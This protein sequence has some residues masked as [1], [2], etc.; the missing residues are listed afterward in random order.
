MKSRSHTT[1]LTLGLVL[2]A[3]VELGLP[4]PRAGAQVTAEVLQVVAPGEATDCGAYL[5]GARWC[6]SLPLRG[7]LPAAA[8]RRVVR[9]AQQTS[10]A[11]AVVAESPAR[12]DRLVLAHASHTAAVAGCSQIIG[13][14]NDE[15]GGARPH[16]DAPDV[17]SFHFPPVWGEGVGVCT[18]MTWTGQRGWYFHAAEQASHDGWVTG[19]IL[20]TGARHPSV[21]DAVTAFTS[22]MGAWGLHDVTPE[23]NVFSRP[24]AIGGLLVGLRSPNRHSAELACLSFVAPLSVACPGRA[25]RRV[26]GAAQFAWNETLSE[27]RERVEDYS[28]VVLPPVAGA[29]PAETVAE[30]PGATTVA[31]EVDEGHADAGDAEEAEGAPAADEPDA[32]AVAAAPQGNTAQLP[33]KPTITSAP[34][35]VESGGASPSGITMVLLERDLGA[36]GPNGMGGFSPVAVYDKVELCFEGERL[37]TVYLLATEENYEESNPRATGAWADLSFR[38]GPATRGGDVVHPVDCDRVFSGNVTVVGSWD[39]ADGQVR[40]LDVREGEVVD[41]V[42]RIS[43]PAD[44][45]AAPRGRSS[46]R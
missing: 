34:T 15:E 30:T 7:A 6:W 20:G 45:P 41:G 25:C 5:C 33:V 44:P 28:E 2:T 16:D 46:R 3:S 31:A 21:E 24:G 17:D 19:F 1:A 42:V 12:N 23:V 32:P 10:G 18:P 9:W 4:A 37:Q 40:F 38:Y 35:V 22:Q 14:A 11:V 8:R 26:P 13:A 29:A 43:R 36:G 39:R 27:L